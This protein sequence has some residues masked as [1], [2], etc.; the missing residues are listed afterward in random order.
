VDG[1]REKNIFHACFER[2]GE[3]AR[4]VLVT[5]AKRQALRSLLVLPR[6]VEGKIEFRL[7]IV[8]FFFTL[9]L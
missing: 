2:F 6:D 8:M 5:Q 3:V 1:F 9:S 7:K 4:T